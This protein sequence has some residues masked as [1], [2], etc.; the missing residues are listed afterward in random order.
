MRDIVK[1]GVCT[2]IY[3]YVYVY[4]HMCIYLFCIYV[5]DIDKNDNKQSIWC[6]IG[7]YRVFILFM[8]VYIDIH[9]PF[10]DRNIRK[11]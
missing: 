5:C 4:V 6:D 11:N 10:C 1:Y 9:I 7:K 3:I 8:Y 2:Y